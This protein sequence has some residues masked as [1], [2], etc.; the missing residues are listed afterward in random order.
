MSALTSSMAPIWSGV[1]VYGNASSSSRC[2]GVSGENAYPGA[3]VRA[4][5]SR[6]SSPAICLTALR[7]RPFAFCQS[8]PPRRCTLGASPPT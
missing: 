8:A 1:S 7:A 6:I 3:D 2:Q 4:A 5:Y